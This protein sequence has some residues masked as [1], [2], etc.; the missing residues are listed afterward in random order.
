MRHINLNKC[1]SGEQCAILHRQ[2]RKEPIN[3]ACIKREMMTHSMENER[4]HRRQLKREV[5]VYDAILIAVLVAATTAI[6]II[7]YMFG[8]SL[9]KLLLIHPRL[10][11]LQ[12]ALPRPHEWPWAL[13]VAVT[14]ALT[15][16]LINAPSF[17]PYV[18]IKWR[19]F[20]PA[21][22]LIMLPTFIIFSIAASYNATANPELADMGRY[23]RA[24]CYK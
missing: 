12:N 18:Q 3:Y 20:Q 24:S 4:A 21:L 7:L 17:D 11:D 16:S 2:M 19:R 14:A 22:K 8:L 13:S 9:V 5:I 15:Y 6:S 10:D 1:K 23:A